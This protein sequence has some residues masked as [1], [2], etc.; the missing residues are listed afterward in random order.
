MTVREAV[1]RVAVL[2]MG[3]MVLS[4]GR[5]AWNVPDDLSVWRSLLGTLLVIVGVRIWDLNA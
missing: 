5:I 4:L 3:A 1:G 2:L